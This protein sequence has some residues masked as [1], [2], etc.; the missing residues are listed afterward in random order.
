MAAGMKKL[1]KTFVWILMGM[2]I[3]GLAGFGA[4]NFTGN[5]SAVAT[6]GDQEISVQDYAR[7]LQREQQ[8]LQQQTGQPMTISQMV[9]F[10]L[11]RAVLSRLVATAA[12]DNEV[13][14]LG[15]SIGDETLLKEITQIDAFHNAAGEFDR[16]TYSFSL[17]RAG[18]SERQFEEDV[19]RETA[20]ILVQ[21]AMMSAVEMPHTMTTVITDYIGARRSF[22]W[23]QLRTDETAMIA[24][25]PTD[26]ELQGFYEANPALFTLPETKQITYALL[27]PD[28]VLEEI[29]VDEATLR[30]MYEERSAEYQVPERRLVE[31]LVFVNED[32]ATAAKAAID[33]G[34]TTFEALV[35]D[36]GLALSDVDMG[37]VAITE[38]D[39]AGEAVFAAETGTVT[40]PQPTDL[41]PALF[42]INGL[43][44][45]RSTSFEEAEAALRDE[46][47][48]DRAR[49]L[50]E[51]QSEEI[52]DLLAGGIT[53]EELT[54]EAGLEVSS[55]SWTAESEEGVAAY[56]AFREAA[57][58]VSADDFPEVA[59]LE[60]G[61]L[62]ALRLD[63]VLPERPEPL[64]D[65]QDKAL[66]GWNEEQRLNALKTQA[67]AILAR[68]ETNGAFDDGLEVTS[69]TGLTRTAYIDGT[70]ADMMNA[71]FALEPGKLQV[72]ADA[73]STVILRLTEVLPPEQ[74]DDLAALEDALASQ[75]DQ[76][77]AEAIYQAFAADSQLRA[78]PTVDQSAIN[79]V[80]T[81]FQ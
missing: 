56:S 26:A 55:L 76:A 25:A 29:E 30:K 81:T 45:A 9:S 71:V 37:D 62:F 67:D 31:R 69:E 77:L 46:V 2:L 59:F 34:E 16:D 1:S 79:A 53:L 8:R 4:V 19:R 35:Q 11:D 10:G 74:T 27:S 28:M 23:V 66:R 3:V 7:A 51:D 18:L 63:D 47:A 40:D 61:S 70:P 73:E 64:A 50:I 52:D 13:E 5:A 39:T 78:Q 22:D 24:V 14:A 17:D 21:E 49:R 75:L 44:E 43:L 32:E 41:G 72:V 54:D 42:R 15:I 65:A 80:H 12:L 57:A 38:L 48:A 58:A 60:D 68:A 6:A 33:A 36:R 20:R